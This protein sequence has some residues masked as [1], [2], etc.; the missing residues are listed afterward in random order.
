MR[1]GRRRQS[2]K[3]RSSGKRRTDHKESGVELAERER[4]GNEA[5][6]EGQG[7]DIGIG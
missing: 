5:G 6:S 3:T 2:Q 4:A 1:R 7:R